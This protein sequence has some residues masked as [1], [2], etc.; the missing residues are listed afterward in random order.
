MATIYLIR[1]C[2]ATGQEADAPLTSLGVQQ[3]KELVTFFENIPIDYIVSSPFERAIKTAEPLAREKGLLLDKDARLT[4]RI[5]CDQPLEDWQEKLKQTYVDFDVRFGQGE[6]SREAQTRGLSC[7]HEFQET[8]FKHLVVVS[9][10]NLISLILRYF[11]P[12]FGY[13]AWSKLTNPDVYQINLAERSVKRIYD[14]S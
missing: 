11:D 3:A 14:Q 7:I 1:H 13:D 5:L 4:E 9:H 6:T 12:T 2:Q 8:G 10:G